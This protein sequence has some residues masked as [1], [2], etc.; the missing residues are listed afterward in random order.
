MIYIPN[1]FSPNND[2]NNDILYVRGENVKE[3]TFSIYN[4][5]GEKVFESH[6]INKGWDG[7]QNGKKCEAGVYVYRA[8]ITFKDGK[9]IMKRGDVTLVR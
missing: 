2:G 4:R 5:W 8:E 7:T 1:I 6:D 3:L 9:T